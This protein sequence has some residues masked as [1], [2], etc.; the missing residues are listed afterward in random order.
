MGDPSKKLLDDAIAASGGT[1]GTPRPKISIDKQ[2]EK[3]AKMVAQGK[4]HPLFQGVPDLASDS[5]SPLAAGLVTAD[6]LADQVLTK[7]QPEIP[8][9]IRMDK[10]AFKDLVLK[11]AVERGVVVDAPHLEDLYA[12][13][14][15][16]GRA[17]HSFEVGLYLRGVARAN[18]L[19]LIN[20]LSSVVKNLENIVV[21]TQG[22]MSSSVESVKLS[23]EKLITL[24][25][26]VDNIIPSLS[27]VISADGSR[28]RA[29]ITNLAPKL[30]PVLSVTESSVKTPEP[31]KVITEEMILEMC[32]SL[33]MPSNV[34]SMTYSRYGSMITWEVYNK[35]MSGEI[36]MAGFKVLMSGWKNAV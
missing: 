6:S 31:C 29:E 4:L 10:A 24:G 32:K 2:A 12:S 23:N 14:A 9:A 34:A 1:K 18:Q 36:N 33:G 19:S 25:A 3:A 13:C 5:T 20:T 7:A 15:I 17:L 26:K 30:T 28:T 35:V 16:A 22:V 21:K 8:S 27:S 11:M